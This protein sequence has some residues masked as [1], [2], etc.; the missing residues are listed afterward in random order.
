M[1]LTP[2]EEKQLREQIREN[3]EKRLKRELE[4]REIGDS[5]R[6]EKLEERLRKQ[7]REEE[8]ERFYNEKGF[9][10]Y[11][12]RRGGVEWLTPE[13]AEHRGSKRRTTK[14]SSRH[15]RRAQKKYL[16]WGLNLAAA[17]LALAV[18]LYLWRY[19][20]IQEKNSG[21]LVIRSNVPGAH[22]FLNGSEKRDVQTP[23]TLADISTGAYFV[24]VYKDGYSVW[25]PMQR[26]S[27]EKG[28]TAVAEFELKSAGRIGQIALETNLSGISVYLDGIRYPH[29]E[30]KGLIDVPVGFH[31]ITVLKAGHVSYP[32]YQRILVTGEGAA[33]VRVELRKSDTVGFLRVTSNRSSAYVY[34][35]DRF[36]GIRANGDPFPVEAGVYQVRLQENG[37]TAIPVSELVRIS[38][39]ETQSL[40]FHLQQ[41]TRMDTLQVITPTAGANIILN[42]EMLPYLTPMP[43]LV[44]GEGT[45][46]LNF[47][48]DGR[49]YAEKDVL[50]EYASLK[51]KV[52]AVEF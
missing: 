26:L 42:G 31:V 6:Q 1:A 16:Q 33:P 18:F 39:G 25:P 20:P 3:L 51:Q 13:E 11:V 49:M 41:S 35:S 10:P 40:S 19:N 28:R 17:A 2:E 21:A 23:D 46:F 32:P 9:T 47:M 29:D 34:L 50:I 5:S 48:R 24:T 7:I 8:E 4:S 12:N 14:K 27:V 52:V 15:K 43:D 45:Q 30:A 36:S 37:F 22:V 38:P 44:V